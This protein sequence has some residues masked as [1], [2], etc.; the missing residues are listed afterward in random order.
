MAASFAAADLTQSSASG[1]LKAQ[2]RIATENQMQEWKVVVRRSNANLLI[3]I[4]ILCIALPL[5]VLAQSSTNQFWPETEAFYSFSSNLRI[6]VWASRSNDGE[7]YDSL[8]IGTTL[9]FYARRF[10]QPV[11]NTPDD[12]KKKMLVFGV[13]YNFIAGINQPYENRIEVDATPQFK[14]PLAIQASD[15]NRIDLRFIDGAAFTWRYRNS[16]TFQ[17]TFKVRRLVFSPYAQAEF[18]RSADP[19]SWNKFTCQFGSDFS[20]RKRFVLEPYYE[21]DDNVGSKPEYVNAL[22]VTAYVYF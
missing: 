4:E 13:G 11:L 22:G 10:V 12:A 3:S 18:F 21:R 16:P 17:R 9:N 20:I 15:R 2:A 8:S 14:L 19:R 1:H 5:R 7:S 6:G